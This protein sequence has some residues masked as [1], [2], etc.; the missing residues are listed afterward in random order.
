MSG[1]AGSGNIERKMSHWT[2]S[3]SWN[4]S[5]SA[6]RKRLRS[7]AAAVGSRSAAASSTSTSSKLSVAAARR[8]VRMRSMDRVTRSTSS[9]SDGVATPSASGPG[10]RRRPGMLIAV[11]V[12]C[13]RIFEVGRSSRSSAAAASTSAQHSAASWAESSTIVASGS[14]PEVMPSVASTWVAKPWIVVIVAA[15]NSVTARCRRPRRSSRSVAASCTSSGSSVS[16]PCSRW[17][18]ASTS[19]SRTRARSSEVAARVKVTMSRSEVETSRSARNLVAS[20]ARA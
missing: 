2:G 18:A 19:R 5:I 9:R 11:R 8:R 6:T 4:S 16:P 7:V 20:A 14:A 12:R 17:A 3:V 10:A 1:S 13:T 15:S